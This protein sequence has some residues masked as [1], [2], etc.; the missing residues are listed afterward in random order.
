MTTARTALRLSATLL[1]L[2]GTSYGCAS[3]SY[4]P[5][6]QAFPP[7]NPEIERAIAESTPCRRP[8]VASTTLS[9]DFRYG[10]FCGRD[11]PRIE[12]PSEGWAKDFRALPAKVRRD[13]VLDLYRTRPIDTVDLACRNHDICMLDSGGR[14][15][16]CDWDMNAH[17]AA[18]ERHMFAEQMRHDD[19]DSVQYRCDLLV[20]VL[21]TGLAV[22]AEPSGVVGDLHLGDPDVKDEI[23]PIFEV[24]GNELPRRGERCLLRR[25]DYQWG[26]ELGPQQRLPDEDSE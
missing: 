24:E 9:R 17:L 7:L 25:S 6:P 3:A 26:E 2:L 22:D 20:Q 4:R 10:C 8:A 18:I 19:L 5:D 23:D 1:F 21:R 11:Y 16:R 13:R 15:E 14:A 12:I